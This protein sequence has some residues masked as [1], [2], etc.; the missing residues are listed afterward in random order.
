MG[1]KLG[2]SNGV[3]TRHGRQNGIGPE[4]DFGR[5]KR[6]QNGIGPE[7]DLGRNKRRQNGIGPE[8]D[9]GRNK[10]GLVR[11]NVVRINQMT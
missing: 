5:N 9:L 3:N 4:F 8:F 2:V 7:F 6:R 1:E 10:G 11:P